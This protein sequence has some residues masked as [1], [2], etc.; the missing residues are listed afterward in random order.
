M[1]PL[2]TVTEVREVVNTDLTDDA[3]ERLIAEAEGDIGAIAGDH[4][5]AE[6]TV[7]VDGG[8]GA[9]WIGTGEQISTVASITENAFGGTPAAVSSDDYEIGPGGRYIKKTNGLSWA[10]QVHITYTPIS[11]VER[12]KAI[13]IR[14]VSL[15]AN[16]GP[17]SSLDVGVSRTFKDFGKEKTALLEECKVLD[18][19][20][21]V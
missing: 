19:S 14:L 5:A 9:V 6:R 18:G 10:A 16:Y 11:Q 12:R 13:L 7:D 15:S 2:L 8:F 20:S 4:S 21:Y 1:P 3:V 17:F